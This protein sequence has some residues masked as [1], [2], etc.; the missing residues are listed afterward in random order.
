MGGGN[1]LDKMVCHIERLRHASNGL[2]DMW[3]RMGTLI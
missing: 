3:K 1:H 2:P